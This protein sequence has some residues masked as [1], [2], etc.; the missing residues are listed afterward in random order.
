MIGPVEYPFHKF[1]LHV[2]VFNHI[3]LLKSVQI[4]LQAHIAVDR[5]AKRLRQ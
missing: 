4:V 3:Y 2:G 1:M 5:D